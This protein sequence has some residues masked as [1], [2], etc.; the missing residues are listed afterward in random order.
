MSPEERGSDR[1]TEEPGGGAYVPRGLQW[2]LFGE[3]VVAT[4]L[5]AHLRELGARRPLILTGPTIAE[6]TNLLETVRDALPGVEVEIFQDIRR[7]A[8]LPAILEASR[9]GLDHKADS[10]I[11][12]GGGGVI[13]AGKVVSAAV[14]LGVTSSDQFVEKF[15]ESEMTSRWG[16]G[17]RTSV[18][19]DF[20]RR[21]HL[22]IP[23]TLVGAA[24]TP[25]GGI[26]LSEAEGK[27]VFSHP[28]LLARSV[29]L[30]P[31]FTQ[32]TPLVLWSS[33]GIKALEHS[34]E[35]YCAPPK[36]PIIDPLV[37]ES[38]KTIYK[39]LP[40]SRESPE[41]RSVRLHLLV[42]S[43]QAMFGGSR[44]PKSGLSHALTR[45]LGGV[46][47]VPHGLACCV[48]LP[49]AMEYNFSAVT[50]KLSTIGLA[51]ASARGAEVR[52]D[53][54]EY[55]L[56]CV[57]LLIGELGLPSRLRD[58]Q[59]SRESLPLVAEKVFH[60]HGLT[61]NPRPVKNREIIFDLLKK[62]W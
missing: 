56:S 54:A 51:F 61:S 8:F 19:P 44:G 27:V 26:V 11:S 34:I 38:A 52:S 6:K 45:Q 58:L 3:G 49:L 31:V 5:L 60:D 48:T 1:C 37:L 39:Y 20:P 29:L 9:R 16:E 21:V 46:C 15:K 30:D 62:A 57:K 32:N 10:V 4:G 43:W 24:H 42:A 14:T 13:D 55:A 41:D 47:G 28:L 50:E 40:I 23:T 36:H 12:V 35:K 18:L 7:G 2:V 53:P 17:V 59:V 22:A 25:G 33:S